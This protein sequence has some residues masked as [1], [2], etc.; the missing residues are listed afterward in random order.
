[1][2]L[3]APTIKG[4]M[5]RPI[6]NYRIIRYQMGQQNLREEK[7]WLVAVNR[8]YEKGSGLQLWEPRSDYTYVCGE[9]FLTGKCILIFFF[10]RGAVFFAG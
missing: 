10:L 9:H 5:L 4:K 2:C 8:T 7:R 1:M 6:E 3:D